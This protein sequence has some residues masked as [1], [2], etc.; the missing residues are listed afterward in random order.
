M[1]LS[2][3]GR[4]RSCCP[5]LPSCQALTLSRRINADRRSPIYGSAFDYI[6][7]ADCSLAA[8]FDHRAMAYSSQLRQRQ[9]VLAAGRP[10]VGSSRRVS[11]RRV[12]G[13]GARCQAADKGRF[14]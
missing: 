6:C 3:V 1:E 5:D 4:P 11:T 9:R 12:G 2:W 14:S 7:Y 8:L 13:G 10:T